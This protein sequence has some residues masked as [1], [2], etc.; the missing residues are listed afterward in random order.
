MSS[1]QPHAKST[2]VTNLF[3]GSS[4]D[5]QQSPG[6]NTSR[7]QYRRQYDKLAQQKARLVFLL[8]CRRHKLNPRFIMDKVNHL[9]KN[10]NRV[11]GTIKH[12]VKSV[13][14]NLKSKLLNIEISICNSDIEKLKRQI[15]E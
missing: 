3:I 13:M 6:S 5:C 11:S 10:Y 15:E 14:N 7:R 12:Q 1:V 2:T 9:L 8:K 4:I